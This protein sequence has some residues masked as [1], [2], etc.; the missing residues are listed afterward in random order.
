MSLIAGIL[1]GIIGMASL[2]LYP[3]LLSVGVPPVSANATITVATVGAGVGTTISSL[4]ELRHHWGSAILVA[5]LSTCGSIC[6]ALILT[7]S[8]NAGFQK[9]VPVFILLAGILLLW[10]TSG[11][12]RQRS[13]HFAWLL[14]WAGVILI[15]L[16]NGYFGAASGLLMIAVLSKAIGGEYATYNAVRNFA[17]LVNNICSAVIFICTIRI[18]WAI[19]GFL[20]LGLLVGGYLG[21]IIV[22]YIPS[23][24][25]KK[26]VGVIAILL[27]LVLG[28]QAIH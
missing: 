10:P 21:P 15:G 6:G 3:V 11:Q 20:L 12:V 7:R 19:I 4:K 22:R 23:A 24:V 16:Y 14:D 5:I 28:W 9:I 8:S 2:T 27:A 17:S 18:Q 26:V 13:R 25:I 1:T